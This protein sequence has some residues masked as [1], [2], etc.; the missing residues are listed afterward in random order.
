MESDNLLEKTRALGR[1]LGQ[2]PG[3]T[4]SGEGTDGS[5]TDEMGLPRLYTLGI[6]GTGAH[7]NHNQIRLSSLLERA[8][9][10]AV[11]IGRL[12]RK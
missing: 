12:G 5:L 6:A 9:L 4:D 10:S 2:E 8:Q 3:V 11:L 7:S 1:L